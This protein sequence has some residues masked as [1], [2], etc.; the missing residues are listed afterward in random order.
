[1]IAVEFLLR[2]VTSLGYPESQSS[3]VSLLKKKNKVEIELV[4]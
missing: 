4:L 3:Y 2:R 1:M